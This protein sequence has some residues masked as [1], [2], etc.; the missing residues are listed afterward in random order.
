[1]LYLDYSR[2]PGQ[3]HPNKFGGRENLEAI[4]FIKEANATAYKNNPGIV[5]I[6]WYA[7][8]ARTPAYRCQSSPGILP[9][10]D[11]LP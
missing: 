5:M 4:D 1:M 2:E 10:S 7:N 8:N 3:W 6:A 11:P 9:K